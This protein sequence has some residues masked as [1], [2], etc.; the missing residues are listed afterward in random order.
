MNASIII[1]FWILSSFEVMN[2]SII[3]S[4]FFTVS[5]ATLHYCALRCLR[6]CGKMFFFFP[7]LAHLWDTKV[8]LVSRKQP[9]SAAVITNCSFKSANARFSCTCAC[10]S[11]LY[12]ALEVPFQ[13]KWPILTLGTHLHFISAWKLCWLYCCLAC[14][15]WSI[16]SRAHGVGMTTSLVDMPQS[17]R[18]CHF[19]VPLLLLH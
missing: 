3:I 10:T 6:Y 8:S 18:H 2:A 16:I 11:T 19:T 5:F 13:S 15:F 12:I 1:I 7:T 17:V 4:F 14:P 9:N